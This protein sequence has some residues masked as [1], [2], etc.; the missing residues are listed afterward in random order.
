MAPRAT[1]RAAGER[2]R[3][4]RYPASGPVSKGGQGRASTR[5]GCGRSTCGTG[6]IA[7]RATRPVTLRSRKRSAGDGSPSGPDRRG[8]GATA[9]VRRRACHRPAP[10]GRRPPSGAV[11]GPTTPTA[12]PFPAT[13]PRVRGRPAAPATRPAPPPR[14]PAAPPPRR[15]ARLP[16]PPAPP[17]RT[18]RS[19]ATP[20]AAHRPPGDRR[21]PHPPTPAL[22][23][24]IR[25]PRRGRWNRQ[26]SIRA[27]PRATSGAGAEK[28]LRR[29]R[30]PATLAFW[31]LP[32]G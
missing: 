6:L 23:P 1:G 7:R 31:P 29:P 8:A 32:C 9:D 3:R 19:G 10:A 2:T 20:T 17:G 25:A 11:S 13:S 27:R 4:R 30:C 18:G 14:R 15:P 16:R 28:L 12:L 22:N 26:P 5:R 24:S 21:R